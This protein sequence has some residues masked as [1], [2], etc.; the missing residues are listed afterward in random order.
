MVVDR[1]LYS[2]P[3]ARAVCNFLC[4]LAFPSAWS[5]LQS[6]TTWLEPVDPILATHIPMVQTLLA[7]I[8]AVLEGRSL[9]VACWTCRATDREA[10]AVF[11]GQQ[12]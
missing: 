9:T 3:M 10:E 12:R 1:W 6:P 7:F 5:T 2:M 11:I 4:C 8:Q